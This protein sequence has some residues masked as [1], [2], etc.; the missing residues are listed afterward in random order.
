[1]L[2]GKS[3]PSLTVGQRTPYARFT[4]LN[5]EP[6]TLGD[7]RGK[8]VAV[9]F[10]A[11]TC[12]HSP[13]T[14]ER[15][16]RMVAKIGKDKATFLAASLDKTEAIAEVK[17]MIRLRDMDN[18]T[19]AISGNA[20]YDEAYLALKGSELPYVLLIAAD[21]VLVYAGGSLGAVE[22]YFEK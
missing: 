6:V 5:G 12:T 4:L 8:P 22:E 21:G 19:H 9:I 18:L 16:N 14:V 1:M 17:E 10:W 13:K 2:A 11:S 7:L 20:E 15:L 3:T